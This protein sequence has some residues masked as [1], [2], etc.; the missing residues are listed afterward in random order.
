M[1]A[2]Q[3]CR[4]EY[5][6]SNLG[7]VYKAIHVIQ[8]D[9]GL[10]GVAAQEASETLSGSFGAMKA[11][12][13]NFFGSLAIGENVNKSLTTLISSATTFLFD[14]LIPMVGTVIKALPGA[15]VT[16]IKQGVPAL[17]SSISGL[18]N[19]IGA[20]LG[21]AANNITSKK[22]ANWAKTM[23]PKFASAAKNVIGKFAVSLITGLPK[24]TSAIGKIGLAIV[25]G[26]GSQ[27]WGKVKQAANGIKARFMAP[28][29]SMRDK[30]KGI[31]N[32][33]KGFFPFN[34]GKIIDLKLPHISIKTG[35]KSVFGKTITYPTGF[36]ISWN[37]KAMLNP[38]MFS[39]PTLF[40][41]GEAGDEMLYGKNAL[42]GDIR[43]AVALEGGAGGNTFYVTLNANGTENPEQYAQ[44]VARELKRQ[45][46]MGV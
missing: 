11:A 29:E 46:R 43:K 16:F 15:I 23:L 18:I 6:I 26:L 14:N 37:R 20:S 10:T 17:L 44:R 27:L 25:R 42:M 24:I 39:N 28:I 21:S 41:A 32:K 2:G 45:V 12:A 9:L 30:V 13:Q 19:S 22:V 31:I 34:V 8:E 1:T 35:S 3:T 5:D 36:D 7:D 40:G 4:Q 33:I 38:Y